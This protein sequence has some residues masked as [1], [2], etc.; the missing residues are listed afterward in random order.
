M[1]TVLESLNDGLRRTLR[2][3]NDVLILGEDILDPYGGAFKVSRNLSVEFPQ[4]VL[5]TPISEAGL[6]GV[7]TGLALRGFRPVV[8][9]M[10]GD[11]STLIADQMI[12]H[13]SK[14]RSMYGTDLK[15]PVVV[16]T[17][18]GGRRGY[19]P[20][21]SQ[22]IEKLYFGI[23]DLK[24]IAPCHYPGGAG[25]LL[26]KAILQQDGPVFFVENK[27]QYLIKM[28]P[29]DGT[30]DLEITQFVVGDGSAEYHVRVRGAPPADTFMITYGY[31]AELAQQ[32]ALTLAY[33]HE[34]FTEILVLAQIS[35]IDVRSIQPYLRPEMHIVILE[36]GPIGWGWGAEVSA[37]ISEHYPHR[38]GKVRRL[39]SSGRP[40]PAS[41]N[42]ERHALPQVEDI[43]RAVQQMR[44]Q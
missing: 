10:F 43:V 35:P 39:A 36:E 7:A 27:L 31:M 24:V 29:T 28:L 41:I 19:G 21:H 38:S 1:T 23:P 17:P 11:F 16:R 9:I 33:Q 14:M 3:S 30:E 44:G 37:Q 42:L 12:N 25:E 26:Y 40:I 22:T 2:D 6:V 20:T 5:A 34:I 18:M 4:R 8:E 15:L 32:A 13:L